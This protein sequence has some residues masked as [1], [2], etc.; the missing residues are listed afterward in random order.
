MITNPDFSFPL[1]LHLRKFSQPFHSALI[2]TEIFP[3]TAA[4]EDLT[5]NEVT[6]PVPRG[7]LIPLG[8]LNGTFL[9]LC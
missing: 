1:P 9:K 6:G 2:S 5:L 3:L 8:C 4:A 7:L